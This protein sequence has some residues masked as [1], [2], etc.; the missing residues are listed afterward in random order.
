MA[1]MGNARVNAIWEAELPQGA[2]PGQA[3]TREQGLEFS[4]SKYERKQY[5]RAPAGGQ[6]LLDQLLFK[7]VI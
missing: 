5:V 1:S 3:A 2:K 4:K 6:Q 7:A